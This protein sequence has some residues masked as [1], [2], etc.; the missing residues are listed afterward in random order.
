MKLSIKKSRRYVPKGD[1]IKDI[2]LG[3]VVVGYIYPVEGEDYRGIWEINND[4]VCRTRVGYG[5]KGWSETPDGYA[6][7]LDN[8]VYQSEI[9]KALTGQQYEGTSFFCWDKK[10]TIT[11]FPTLRE[12]RKFA[13][14]SFGTPTK[15]R[16]HFVEI[17]LTV[18]RGRAD[19]HIHLYKSKK[20][21]EDEA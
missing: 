6:V 7:E 3:D 11:I 16:S 1:D 15:L 19:Y 5:L 4:R 12:A 20:E 18:M 2:I 17:I 9:F 14:D 21:L 8:S 10:P 13:R